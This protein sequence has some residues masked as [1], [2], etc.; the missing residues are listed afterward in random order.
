[1]ICVLDADP[2]L[3]A[4]LEPERAARARVLS[5]AEVIAIPKGRWDEE[6]TAERARGGFGLLVLDGVLIREAGIEGRSGAELLATADLL[7]PWERDG[8]R[9]VG[10]CETAWQ[11]L[12]PARVAV[13]DLAWAERMSPFPEVAARL[14]GRVMGRARRLATL[15]AITHQPRLDDRLVLLLWELA[16]RHGKVGPDGVRL[17]LPLTHELLSH[18]AAARRPSISASLTRLASR[19]VVRRDGRAWIIAGDPP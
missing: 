8:G 9:A 13:L 17:T 18:L 14:M 7:R 2:D 1:M 5:A 16:D 11:V 12:E 15:M 19:G 6:R 10:A 3:A 4:E